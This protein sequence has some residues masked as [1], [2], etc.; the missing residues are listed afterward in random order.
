GIS[1][2]V[3]ATNSL[4]GSSKDDRVGYYYD[5]KTLINGNYLV[6]SSSWDNGAATD[7]GAVTFGDG[8]SGVSGVVS[9]TNSL[10]GSSKDDW[11][12]SYGVMTLLNGNYLV[13]SSSWDDGAATD[14]GVVYSGHCG[15]GI[16]GV[17]S[18][19]NSLV[20]RSKDDRVGGYYPGGVTA[21]PNGNYL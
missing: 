9:V 12:G 8:L 14:A 21:L 2:V 3:S 17:V 11:I 10:V 7:A 5:V 20:G 13:I 15:S 19:T 18:A 6:I 16:S 4:V 1:G